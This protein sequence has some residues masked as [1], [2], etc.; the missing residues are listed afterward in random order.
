MRKRRGQKKEG[1]ELGKN[2]GQWGE[3]WD[4]ETQ[5]E[6]HK[7]ETLSCTAFQGRARGSGGKANAKKWG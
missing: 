3:F 4:W 2:S 5:Y 6:G 1:R 7:S